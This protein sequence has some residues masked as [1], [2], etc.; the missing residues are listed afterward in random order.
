MNPNGKSVVSARRNKLCLTADDT[1]AATAVVVTVE[2]DTGTPGTAV[3]TVDVDVV[4]LDM[5]V[6][7]PATAVAGMGGEGRIILVKQGVPGER[8]E[9]STTVEGATNPTDWW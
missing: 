7:G 4:D 9:G 2:V 5:V 8:I 6:V 1:E 3:V